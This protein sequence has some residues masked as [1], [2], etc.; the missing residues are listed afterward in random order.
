[1]FK[2]FNTFDFRTVDVGGEEML[3][4]ILPHERHRE[5]VILGSDCKIYRSVDLSGELKGSNMHDL[6]VIDSGETVLTL[7][8]LPGNST[9]E[10]SAA[11]GFDGNC[12]T[13]WEVRSHFAERE[14][15]RSKAYT[16]ISVRYHRVS[17]SSVY[18]TAK[19][20]SPG[21][22]ETGLDSTKA[23]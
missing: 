18:R 23:L 8:R 22:R 2:H 3:S 9:I 15:W 7:T 6:N 21:A 14:M 17:R 13:G 4:L 19:C 5:G 20:S 10:Q 1:M 12:S 16:N 11:V